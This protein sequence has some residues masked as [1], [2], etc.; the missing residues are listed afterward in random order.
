MTTFHEL[1]EPTKSEPKGW[2]LDWTPAGGDGPTAG[3]L[4]SKGSFEPAAATDAVS[5]R[6]GTAVIG[7]IV[8]S[9]VR[10]TPYARLI[11]GCTSSYEASRPCATTS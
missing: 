9:L 4:A 6:E 3:V 1:T 7:Q 8:S 11:P 5:A 10:A 2:A